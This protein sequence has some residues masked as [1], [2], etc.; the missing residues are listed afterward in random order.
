MG[1]IDSFFVLPP[2]LKS[3][4]MGEDKVGDAQSCK[5]VGTSLLAG[6]TQLGD[7]ETAPPSTTEVSEMHLVRALPHHIDVEK[8]G[9]RSDVP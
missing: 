1:E 8:S 6:T 2:S 7:T 9:D 4:L 3:V 5:A